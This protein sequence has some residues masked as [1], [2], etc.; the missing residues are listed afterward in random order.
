MRISISTVSLVLVLLL[1]GC[2]G[3][4]GGTSSSSTTTTSPS[5]F[6]TGKTMAYL[7]HLIFDG[8]YLYVVDSESL[9]TPSSYGHL[10]Q[11][12]ATSGSFVTTY[13]NA[14]TNF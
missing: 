7:R 1:H 9:N 12:G 11:F 13:E 6:T 3:G 5:I 2:G 14:T 4:G 8:S 10:R